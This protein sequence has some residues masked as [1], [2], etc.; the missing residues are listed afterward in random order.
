[1]EPCYR[2]ASFLSPSTRISYR[3]IQGLGEAI[4]LDPNQELFAI[5]SEPDHM[6]IILEGDFFVNAGHDTVWIGPGDIVGE[7]GFFLGTGRTKSGAAGPAGCRLWQCSRD[8][9]DTN[10]IQTTILLTH[11]IMG[12]APFI[13]NRISTIFG[14][15]LDMEG[16]R[17]RSL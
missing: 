2:I 11:L 12:L 4:E 3:K 6:Y 9:L 5:D 17:Q 10:S 7:I 16:P 13:Q 14:P 1:M 15:L 8:L